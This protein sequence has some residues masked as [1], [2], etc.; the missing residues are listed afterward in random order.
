MPTGKKSLEVDHSNGKLSYMA[1]PPTGWETIAQV[2]ETLARW[3][4]AQEPSSTGKQV[5]EVF[6][7]QLASWGLVEW[8]AADWIAYWQGLSAWL[9]KRLEATGL[10]APEA[11]AWRLEAVSSQIRERTRLML[12]GSAQLFEALRA[13]DVAALPLKG[14]LLCAGYYPD[15]GIR[16]LGDQDILIRLG[17]RRKARQVLEELGYRFMTFRQDE[18]SVGKINGVGADNVHRWSCST[19]PCTNSG[20]ASWT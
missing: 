16:A 6:S 8:Q 7:P 11:V 1:E 2:V 15:P 13:V 17:A 12:A 10:I 5:L 4:P 3:L 14:A 18:T 20:A 9:V 19:G